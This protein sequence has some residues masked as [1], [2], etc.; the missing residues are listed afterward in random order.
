MKETMMQVNIST[1]V[2]GVETPWVGDY[3]PEGYCGVLI[4]T[5]YLDGASYTDWKV[6]VGTEQECLQYIEGLQK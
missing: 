5:Q 2:D 1:S 3:S 4:D 6:F